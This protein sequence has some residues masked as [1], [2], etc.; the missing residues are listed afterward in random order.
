MS[1]CW[2]E[3]LGWPGVFLSPTRT[4]S[5]GDT[6]RKKDS[7]RHSGYRWRNLW[8]DSVI[9][10]GQSG[11]RWSIRLYYEQKGKDEFGGHMYFSI[12][13]ALSMCGS[14]LVYSEMH[15]LCKLTTI[16]TKLTARGLD[17]ERKQRFT[18]CTEVFKPVTSDP[19]AV[20]VEQRGQL[21]QL[22][23]KRCLPSFTDF[24][25]VCFMLFVKVRCDDEGANLCNAWN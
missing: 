9:S 4:E 6:V 10:G 23:R 19:F 22:T 13:L 12:G 16:K 2:T 25:Y 3:G 14:I 8:P 21:K 11:I 18:M 1:N 7:R 17:G 20:L 5:T 15:R 24:F